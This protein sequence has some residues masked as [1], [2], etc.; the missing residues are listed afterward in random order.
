MNIDIRRSSLSSVITNHR[1]YFG[2]EFEN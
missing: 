2:H 1:L